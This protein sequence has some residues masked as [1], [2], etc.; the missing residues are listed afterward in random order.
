MPRVTAKFTFETPF[1]I[2]VMDAKIRDALVVE[3]P[4]G[5]G[6]VTIHPLVQKE[7]SSRWEGPTETVWESNSVQVDVEMDAIAF[8]P[9]HERQ[10][11]DAAREHLLR[12]LRRCR[13]RSKQH[14]IDPRWEPDSHRVV[15]V[16]HDTGETHGVGRI[17]V[18]VTMY[19]DTPPSLDGSN[20]SQIGDDLRSD[21]E[22]EIW[23]E[24]LLDAKLYRLQNNYRMAVLNAAVVNHFAIRSLREPLVREGLETTSA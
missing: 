15:F 24:L 19:R 5:T 20:W 6:K 12:F 2:K 11:E 18:A 7:L 13:H 22:C 21:L 17:G 10:F 16:N 1:N 8:P 9:L 14:Q 3:M 4:R 23:E